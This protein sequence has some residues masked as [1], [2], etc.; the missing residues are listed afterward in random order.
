[1]PTDRVPPE[2]YVRSLIAS[3][4]AL[5]NDDGGVSQPDA[6]EVILRKTVAKV[7]E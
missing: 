1:M 2:T 7:S 3:V 4:A 6:Y 5:E